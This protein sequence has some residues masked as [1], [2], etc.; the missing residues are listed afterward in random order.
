MKKFPILVLMLCGFAMATTYDKSVPPDRGEKPSGGAERIRNLAAANQ[1][2]MLIDHFWPWTGSAVSDADA[3]KHLQV[4]FTDQNAAKTADGGSSPSHSVAANEGVLD[5]KDYDSTRELAFFDEAS[6]TVQL[7]DGGTLF[8]SG[9]YANEVSFSN[10]ANELYTDSLLCTA[11]GVLT[12]PTDTTDATEAN[13]TYV[14]EGDT[15]KYKSESAWLTLAA[16]PTAAMIKVGTY[17]GNADATQD[18]T[19]VGF[20]PD[21]IFIFPGKDTRYSVVK[22][23]DMAA[24]ACKLITGLANNWITDAI[25]D[26]IDG[27]FTV[28]DGSIAGAA[29]NYDNM[30]ESGTSYFYIAAASIDNP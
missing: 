17:T 1:E 20:E 22:T 3:G 24:T 4:T 18:I 11:A 14:T 30:N 12:L 2:L 13:L 25:T 10:T 5:T 7:T 27:G 16:S 15:L 23:S 9:T 8:L 28:G 21:V 26:V 29:P 19:G 6:N